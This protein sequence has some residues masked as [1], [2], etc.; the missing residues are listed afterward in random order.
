VSRYDES[1]VSKFSQPAMEL[2]IDKL[3][4]VE[5]KDCCED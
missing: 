3:S 2:D 1:S 5:Y 4:S